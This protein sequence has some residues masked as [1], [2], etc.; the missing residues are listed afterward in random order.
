MRS[1]GVEPGSDAW[2]ASILTVGLR[3]HSSA[4]STYIFYIIYHSRAVHLCRLSHCSNYSG[5][6]LSLP[7]STVLLLQFTSTEV[8]YTAWDTVVTTVVSCTVTTVH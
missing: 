4:T 3:A 8:I 2:K 7:L 1:P 6:P 5:L